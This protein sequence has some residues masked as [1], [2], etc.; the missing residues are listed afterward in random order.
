MGHDAKADLG[1]ALIERERRLDRW[2]QRI[3]GAAWFVT[4]ALAGFYA[5]LVV[6]QIREA[7][8]RHRVGVVGPEAVVTAAVP[9]VVAL[10]VLALLIA[11]LSTVGVFLRFRTAALGDIQ[12]RLASLERMLATETEHRS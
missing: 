2:I 6:G 7:L 10:G 11:A 5:I 12:V 1:W 9:L 8:E 3:C 4:L